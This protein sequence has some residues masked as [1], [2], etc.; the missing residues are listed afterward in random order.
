MTARRSDLV[1]VVAI[2]IATTSTATAKPTTAVLVFL[3][4]VIASR[5]LSEIC[6]DGVVHHTYH[7]KPP[8][9]SI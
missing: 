3:F 4:T 5:R 2:A 8:I 1:R 6:Y 9:Q 7:V